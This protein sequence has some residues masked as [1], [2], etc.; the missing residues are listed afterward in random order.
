[1][2]R[3]MPD[4]AGEGVDFLRAAA[5][6]SAPRFS[7]CLARPERPLWSGDRL[8]TLDAVL[9]RAERKED[10]GLA[11]RNE[12]LFGAP[13]ISLGDALEDAAGDALRRCSKLLIYELFVAT[14][15]CFHF[16]KAL[17]FLTFFPR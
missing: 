2:W 11:A 5:H 17:L 16:N 15:F 12:I 4:V 3:E 6:V 8:G 9:S 7:L 10:L 14:T 13:Q 1:M